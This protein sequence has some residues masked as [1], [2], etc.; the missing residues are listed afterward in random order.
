MRQPLTLRVVSGAFF[1][2]C[3]SAASGQLISTN[4]DLAG[5]RSAWQLGPNQGYLSF[6]KTD[7]PRPLGEERTGW[8]DARHPAFDAT[9]DN[10]RGFDF[11]DFSVRVATHTVTDTNGDLGVANV[12]AARIRN[13]FDVANAAYAQAGISIFHAGNTASN[14]NDIVNQAVPAGRIPPFAAGDTTL[15]PTLSNV[16]GVDRNADANVINQYYVNNTPGN[17][18]YALPPTYAARGGYVYSGNDNAAI[19]PGAPVFNTGF[20]TADTAVADTF[21]H[22]LG[23]FLHD[24]NRFTTGN[25]FHS[26]DNND[27]MGNGGTRNIPSLLSKDGGTFGMK[28]VGR[29]NGNLGARSHLS[30]NLTNLAGGGTINQGRSLNASPFV[31][32]VDR[33]NFAGDVADFDWVEDSWHLEDQ[34]GQSD[35]HPGNRENLYFLPG[36]INHSAHTDHDHHNWGELGLNAYAGATFKYA[37]VV[38]VVGRYVDMDVDGSG[39]WSKRESALDYLVEFSADGTNWLAGT[40]IA[41]FT[42]GWTT[43]ASS[44]DFLARWESPVDA[45]ILRIRAVFTGT[46]GHDGN[47]QIDAVIVASQVPEPMMGGLGAIFIS[48]LA[49]RWRKSSRGCVQS[50]H[51]GFDSPTDR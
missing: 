2:F 31:N 10:L 19:L 38:S 46:G 12:T 48:A 21:A 30:E 17:R 32:H 29:Q 7:P 5:T 44:E 49:L 1:V 8:T 33:A 20:A 6:V 11:S 16:L 15:E 34:A 42:E 35:N 50:S 28:D 25:T 40:A 26:S 51:A 18:G 14:A 4:L 3:S 27:L 41:V 43:A 45:T 47:T 13:D 9:R 37:D 39:D 22:E 36:A 23:H 24:T